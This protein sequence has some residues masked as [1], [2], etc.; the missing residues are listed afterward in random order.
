MTLVLVL[1]LLAQVPAPVEAVDAGVPALEL[2]TLTP[3]VDAFG[4]FEARM[5]SDSAAWNAFEVPRVHL[6][7]GAQWRGVEAKVLVEGVYATQ[8][9]ALVGVAGDSLVARLREAWAGYRWNFLEA[10][11]GLVPTL[12]MPE[13]EKAWRF[14]SLSADALERFALQSPADFGVTLSATLPRGYGLVAVA[15]TNGEGYASRELNPNKNV[16]VLAVVHPLP[17]LAAPLAVH[18]VAMVGSQGLP[19]ATTNRF[20]GGVAWSGEAL[21]AGVDAYAVQGL[22]A[23]G[24]RRGVMVQAFARGTLFE[25][26]LLAGRLAWLSRDATRDDTQLE[27]L[28]AVGFG[29]GPL[30]SFVAVGHTFLSGAAKGALPGVEGTDVRV[31]ARFKWSAVV[32]LSMQ[33]SVP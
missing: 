24:G 29:L 1:S 16:E 3:F 19:A 23:D 13:Q 20:G 22:L 9:G 30:E 6:G 11:L 25:H 17:V 2:P 10:R 21:G 31:V 32:P 5:P 33:G 26:L 8:G 12:M 14:R 7:L 28:G 27:V 15:V 18:G 4:A